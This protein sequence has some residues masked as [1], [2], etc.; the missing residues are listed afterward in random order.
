MQKVLFV[1]LFIFSYAIGQAPL[2]GN[3]RFTDSFK[4][5]FNSKIEP[6]PFSLI[7]QSYISSDL[8]ISFKTQNKPD[9]LKLSEITSQQ[10]FETT[11]LHQ[12]TQ[13]GFFGFNAVKKDQLKFVNKNN[14]LHALTLSEYTNEE[15]ESRYLLECTKINQK[16]NYY[17]MVSD[18]KFKSDE[19]QKAE[20]L[21]A[22]L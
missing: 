9:G 12:Q 10:F 22:Q 1:F 4:K 7:N 13:L 8:Y 21:C 15:N 18:R 5:I 14:E 2:S 17:S 6:A 11:A 16:L 19:T 3:S 20:T